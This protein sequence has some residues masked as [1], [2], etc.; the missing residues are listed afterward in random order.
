M[1]FQYSKTPWPRGSVRD[2][3][4]EG[5]GFESW[6]FILDFFIL[7]KKRQ[8]QRAKGNDMIFL[9]V[10]KSVKPPFL[11]RDD[12]IRQQPPSQFQMQTSCLFCIK[13][14]SENQKELKKAFQD[15][16]LERT[17]EATGVI[18][19]TVAQSYST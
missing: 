4:R 3:T 13:L 2:Y 16:Y 11:D 14:L 1:S 12:D 6:L 18:R 7:N 10:T 19:T 17:A 9:C 8:A 5:L 15:P